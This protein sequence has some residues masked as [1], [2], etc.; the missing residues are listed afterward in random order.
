MKS[1][2]IRTNSVTMSTCNTWIVASKYNSPLKGTKNPEKNGWFQVWNRKC[3]KWV[4]VSCIRRQRSN[5]RPLVSCQKDFGDELKGLLV[6][7]Y[8]IIWAIKKNNY[9]GFTYI[10]HVPKCKIHEWKIKWFFT[11]E[12]WETNSFCTGQER[13]RIRHSFCP[14]LLVTLGYPNCKWEKVLF[15]RRILSNKCRRNYRIGTSLFC[16]P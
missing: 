11:G 6:P 8:G 1:L 3:T 12:G 13:E 10:K 4:G 15:C 14:F 5:Q 7:K 16:N 2:E 9:S